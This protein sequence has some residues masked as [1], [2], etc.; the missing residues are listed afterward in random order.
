LTQTVVSP[1]AHA[2]SAAPARGP[3]AVV[4]AGRI[5]RAWAIVFARAGHSVRLHD[6][7]VDAMTDGFAHID[8]RLHE[9][10]D[11]GLLADAPEVVLARIRCEP[12]LADALRDVVLVQENIRES[13]GANTVPI[14]QLDALT[15][16]NAVT[17]GSTWWL[18]TGTRARPDPEQRRLAAF[19]GR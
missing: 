8:A 14:A 12:N 3:I 5:G 15:P 1:N 9:L 16:A 19:R 11:F 4:G 17:A 18:P 10:A 7:D 2:A 6:M 13:V